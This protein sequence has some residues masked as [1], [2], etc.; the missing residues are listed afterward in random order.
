M[1]TQLLGLVGKFLPSIF[2]N[3]LGKSGLYTL[4]TTLTTTILT[5]VAGYFVILWLPL[6]IFTSITTDDTD[7]EVLEH[8]TTKVLDAAKFA[9]NLIFTT[10]GS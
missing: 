5:G 3:T 6:F 4:R 8:T 9:L 1:I 10:K 2:G 7:N